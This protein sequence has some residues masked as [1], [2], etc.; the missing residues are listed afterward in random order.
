ML[1]GC[2]VCLIPSAQTPTSSKNAAKS[3]ICH[4]SENSP[5]SPFL[6]TLPKIAVCKSFVCHTSDTPGVCRVATHLSQ[7]GTRPH[8]SVCFF[9]RTTGQLRIA[10]AWALTIFHFQ[11]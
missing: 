2:A 9:S 3:F 8:A 7:F 1:L 11:G 4:R 6:A 10:A 5:V